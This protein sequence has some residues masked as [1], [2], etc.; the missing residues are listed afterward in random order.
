MSLKAAASKELKGKAGP[1]DVTLALTVIFLL[2][3]GIIMVFSSSYYESFYRHNDYYFFIKKQA[4]WGVLGIFA[5]MFFMNF[6]YWN[7]SKLSKLIIAVA[8]ILLIAVLTPLGIVRNGAQRWLGLG[9]IDIQPSE[10]AKLAMIIFLADVLSKMKDKIKHFFTGLIPVLALTG[11]VCLLILLE[12]DLSTAVSIAG[13]AF[14]MIF[15]AGAQML[16]LSLLTMG[17]LGLGI[18]LVLSEEYRMKRITSFIDPWQD[19]LGTG[20]QIIQSLYALGAGGPF[21]VGI[22]NSL[23]KNFYIPEPQNDFIFAI[24]GE[25]LGFLGGMTVIILFLLLVWRGIRI[26]ISAP[27]LF[28]SFLAVGITGIIAVQVIINIAV[29]TSSMPVT[30]MPLPFISYGGTAL[31]VMMAGVGILLNISRYTNLYK[32]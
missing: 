27:D 22:G 4:M 3:I 16:H 12:P 18:V 7:L 24:L 28:S 15:A 1:V 9:F 26:A 2:T 8:V 19:K 20:Y 23:Q 11:I 13:T 31:L 6:P 14:I 30:G 17:G 5:M 10:F 21:G 32:G 29:V 25:E